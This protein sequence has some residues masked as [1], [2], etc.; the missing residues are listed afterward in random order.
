MS[1][2]GAPVPWNLFPA[3]LQAARDPR[4]EEVLGL[5]SEIQ[6]L[7]LQLSMLVGVEE[8][9][10]VAG[11]EVA[12]FQDLYLSSSDSSSPSS[13]S[14]SD[15]SF[16]CSSTPESSSE[17]SSR[18][19]G[20]QNRA[21]GDRGSGGADSPGGQVGLVQ[22]V[23]DEEMEIT[24]SED[25]EE[26]SGGGQ[27][28]EGEERQGDAQAGPAGVPVK[29]LPRLTPR[30]IPGWILHGRK[31]AGVMS[32]PGLKSIARREHYQLW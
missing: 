5:F 7:G 22:N 28:R 20:D 19:E 30:S 1:R 32:G 23:G 11:Q 17:G 12:P 27:G 2:E 16:S 10:G 13:D 18:E 8:Q 4:V 3:P 29:L 21:G 9:E 25:A 26:A 15:S 31:R 24:R 14:S 6:R